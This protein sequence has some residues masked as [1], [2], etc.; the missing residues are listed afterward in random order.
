MPQ[1]SQQMQHLYNYPAMLQGQGQYN[2]IHRLPWLPSVARDQSLRE[3][4][5]TILIYLGCS[6]RDRERDPPCRT[7]IG[8]PSTHVCGLRDEGLLKGEKKKR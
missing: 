4:K 2:D 5:I 7:L 8:K 1:A 3:D 6:F